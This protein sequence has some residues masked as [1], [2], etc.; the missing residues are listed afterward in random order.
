MLCPLCNAK[1]AC[2][3]CCGMNFCAYDYFCSQHVDHPEK[4]I[5]IDQQ[6]YSKDFQ[7]MSKLM[8]NL[9][10]QIIHE[11]NNAEGIEDNTMESGSQRHTINDLTGTYSVPDHP[12][13]EDD[14]I[15]NKSEIPLKKSQQSQLED[16][17]LSI[18]E[19]IRKKFLNNL[20][21][22]LYDRYQQ[23]YGTIDEMQLAYI[24]D[25]VFSISEEIEMTAFVFCG[26]STDDDY[27]YLMRNLIYNIEIT[28]KIEYIK[29]IIEKKL[30]P[31][32]LIQKD[33]SDWVIQSSTKRPLEENLENRGYI[34]LV[35]T[36]PKCGHAT[37]MKVL[38]GNISS[39]MKGEIWGSKDMP[40]LVTEYICDHCDYR[41]V[42][43]E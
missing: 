15:H 16:L 23:I 3:Q 6:T 28:P 19:N 33:Q 17:D 27:R 22:C 21:D 38:R 14:Q 37:Y 8:S 1:E 42:Q 7:L 40:S 13:T 10:D 26:D 12:M 11:L 29:Q 34:K 36:C 20:N 39:G 4:A 18:P 35:A 30:S 24:Q 41:L 32:E 5:I 2:V 43:E 25:L 31:Q 9:K